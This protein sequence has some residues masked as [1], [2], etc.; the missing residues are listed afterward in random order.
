MEDNTEVDNSL[1]IADGIRIQNNSNPYA[2]ATYTL[3]RRVRELEAEASKLRLD[4]AT[5]TEAMDKL[6]KAAAESRRATRVWR[7]ALHD[8]ALGSE[9]AALDAALK[10]AGYGT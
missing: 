4:L 6:A 1:K 10:E 8:H 7:G 2:V 9:S 3:A 5:K